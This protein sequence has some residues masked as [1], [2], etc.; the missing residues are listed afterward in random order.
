MTIVPGHALSG[1]RVDGPKGRRLWPPDGGRLCRRVVNERVLKFNA[2]NGAKVLRFDG[3]NGQSIKR[4]ALLWAVYG[5]TSTDL[6]I[7]YRMCTARG[8]WYHLGHALRA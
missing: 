5:P 1:V 2:S 7:L 8:L 4:K 3:P 6:H